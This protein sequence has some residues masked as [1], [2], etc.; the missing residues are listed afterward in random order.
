MS[1]SQ[2]AIF[3]ES[4]MMNT[5]KTLLSAAFAAAMLAAGSASAQNRS[6]GGIEQQGGVKTPSATEQPIF[7]QNIPSGVNAIPRADNPQNPN[8]SRPFQQEPEGVRPLVRGDNPNLPNPVTPSAANE[9]APQPMLRDPTN[10]TGMGGPPV[11]ATR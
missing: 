1:S 11:G 8:E 9:S 6:I 4:V 10:T 7:N 5:R 3:Q 2:L